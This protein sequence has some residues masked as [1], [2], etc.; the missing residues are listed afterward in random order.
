MRKQILPK[1]AGSRLNRKI[2]FVPL[3]SCNHAMKL[4]LR[5]DAGLETVAPYPGVKIFQEAHVHLKQTIWLAAIA[6][7]AF[8]FPIAARADSCGIGL[9]TSPTC[10]TVTNVVDVDYGTLTLLSS[11][12]SL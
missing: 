3:L 2:L 12:G 10:F 9:D 5:P 6:A 8:C 11:T 4:S 7:V 1:L